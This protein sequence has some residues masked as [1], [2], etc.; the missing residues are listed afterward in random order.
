[1]ILFAVALIALVGIVALAVDTG[2]LLAERRQNQAAVDS[3]AMAAAIA[4]LD[5]RPGDVV[6]SGQSYGAFNAGVSN[7]EVNVEW[8]APGSGPRTGPDFVRVTITKEVQKFFLGAVY[9][10]NW[11]VTNTAVAGIDSIPKPY[12]LVALNCPG[13][14]LNG[15]I[16]IQIQ[17]EGS[18]ISNCN[19]TNS[20]TSSIFSVGGAIDAVGTIQSNSGWS[21]P[22]GINP[23]QNAAVDPLLN[24]A[25]PPVPGASMV[26]DVPTCLNNSTCIIEPGLYHNKSFT[27]RNTVCMRPGTYYL[28]GNTT[29]S[30]QNTNS[31]LTNK[32]PHSLSG[33]AQ[34]P[35]GSGIGGGVVIYIAPGSTA[36]INLGNGKMDLSTSYSALNPIPPAPA[37]ACSAASAP[38]V[39]APCGIVL[40]IANG[41]AFTNSG[42]AVAK[43]E[44]VIYAPQS[45]VTLQGTP[46]SNGLQVIVGRLSLG[47]N[48]V[49]T[50]EYREYVRLDRPGV[51]LVE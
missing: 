20:G 38:W 36:A 5:K 31:M 47:G 35:T 51:F 33:P 40:W 26:R 50:I 7:A 43:F 45:H 18:A 24:A 44:G 12:A 37:S 23:G 39:G 32:S 41:S 17:G 10:G 42:N 3:A 29:I 11:Q 21:A 46:G 6:T 22:D 4:M 1:M 9:G 49:F 13:I 48:A 34:C 25:P 27:V 14:E 19:I 16:Q 28:S 8:P 15:G 30:F 2:F